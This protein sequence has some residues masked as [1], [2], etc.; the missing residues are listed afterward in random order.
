MMRSYSQILKLIGSLVVLSPALF[1]QTSV[2]VFAPV[3]L[4]PS[5]AGAGTGAN[6]VL[7]NSSTLSLSCP[8]VPVAYLSSGASA[9]PSGSTANIFV[10]NN[11]D[12]TNLTTSNGPVNVC[13]GGASLGNFQYCFNAKYLAPYSGAHEGIDLDLVAANLGVPPINISP[14]LTQG[15]QNLKID[16]VDEGGSLGSSTIYLNTNCTSAGVNGPANISGNVIPPNPPPSTVNQ[17]FNFDSGTQQVVGFTYDLSGALAA[18]TLSINP[19]GVI[20]EVT[21]SGVDPVNGF[22]SLV[23]GT[24]F[25]TSSCLVHN[26]E[27]LNGSPACKLFTLECKTGTGSTSS[28]A[29]CPVSTLSNEVVQD[30]FDGPAFTLPDITGPNGTFHEGMGFLMTSEGWTGGPCTF[31]PAS[32]LQSLFCPLN[33]LTNFSGPGTFTGTGQTTHPNSD[34]I[35]IAQVPEDLTSV[36]VTDST[37]TPVPLGPG[38]WTNNPSPYF[39][40]SS[41]PPVV[42]GTSLPHAANFVAAPIEKITYGISS[43]PTAPAP[44]TTSASDTVLTNTVS[45][46]APTYPANPPAATFTP[47]IQSLSNLVDG[48]YLLH[49][50]ATDCA[51]T[52]E[53]H[54]V[55][56]PN[57]MAWST[58]FYTFPLNIDTVKPEVSSGPVLAPTGPYA[59]NQVVTATF[60]CSDNASGVV[61]CGTKTYSPGVLTTGSIT[62]PVPTAT[63]GLQTFTVPVTDAA[64]NTSSASVQYEVGAS[65]AQVS[66]NLSP[67]PVTYPASVTASVQLATVN[68]HTPTGQV[69]IV[70]EGTVVTTLT[71]SGGAASTSLTGIPVGNYYFVAKYLGDNN[72]NAGVSAQRRATVLPEAVTLSVNCTHSPI[73]NGAS[74]ACSA[75]AIA[76]TGTTLGFETYTLDSGS[77]VNVAL[78]SGV[79]TFTIPTPSVGPH[80]LV[81]NFPQQTNYSASGPITVNFTVNP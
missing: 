16:L 54:F 51:G 68:G 32:G 66:F 43:G 78:R 69:Q 39:K 62:V 67:V 33:L 59:L 25:A 42:A 4:R 58:N 2:D 38:N 60:T 30:I 70:E 46:P 21:D 31:D 56:D 36:T 20:P 52:E 61:L 75:P 81:V 40:L 63:S 41:K 47:A 72:D 45:C 76:T 9:S 50:Y 1:A 74:F 17:N 15:S 19:S 55:Q 37:G 80:T 53:L 24:S 10:D 13:T 12:V 71:L 44:G 73:A 35:T 48:N 29:E 6:Q 77:P 26:G 34:F 57:T 8:A 79:G 22:H 5:Q 64:G 18:G 14:L 3:Y 27:I 28:G 65:D 49:Y 7:F 11:I 23:S